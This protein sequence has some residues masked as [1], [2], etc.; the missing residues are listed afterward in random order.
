MFCYLTLFIRFTSL[1]AVYIIGGFLYQR[2]VVGAKGMEQFPH[3]AFWQDLGNLV[4]VSTKANIY[5][6][7]RATYGLLKVCV[8]LHSH[9]CYT[10]N[11]SGWLN[12][13]KEIAQ[14]RHKE[15]TWIIIM[16][17]IFRVLHIL[18]IR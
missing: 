2:L 15:K 5:K 18:C 17:I 4:A 10:T 7:K 9:G 16:G 12:H 3:F 14:F 8:K 11:F 13:Q 1:V 6:K